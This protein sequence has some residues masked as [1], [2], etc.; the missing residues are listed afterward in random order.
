MI[1]H[2]LSWQEEMNGIKIDCSLDVVVHPTESRTTVLIV[3]GVDGSVDGYE[4]KYIRIAEDLLENK[5]VSVVRI[6]N[7][8]ITSYHWQE[9]LRRALEFIQSDKTLSDK[10]IRIVGHSAGAS[11]I[12]QIAWEYPEISRLLLINPAE[13]LGFEKMQRGLDQF[14][15]LTTILFGGNDPSIETAKDFGKVNGVSVLTVPEASHNFSGEH[16]PIFLSAPANHL[17]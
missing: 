1:T 9:N 13:K 15:G 10:D 6:S 7:P 17:F 3:P 16:F 11:V 14:N 12:A 5:G 8:F 2:T 4:N